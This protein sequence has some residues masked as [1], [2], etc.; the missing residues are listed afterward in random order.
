MRYDS[1]VREL[2]VNLPKGGIMCCA[3]KAPMQGKQQG[4]MSIG[5]GRPDAAQ[6]LLYAALNLRSS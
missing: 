5:K 3:V 2:E 1:A 4:D 6:T